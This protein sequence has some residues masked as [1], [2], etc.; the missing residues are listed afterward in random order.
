MPTGWRSGVVGTPSV[1]PKAEAKRKD[2]VE[3]ALLSAACYRHTL[4]LAAAQATIARNWTTTLVGLPTVRDH[5]YPEG[6]R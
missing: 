6:E 3:D 4:T 5:H 1:E 2:E